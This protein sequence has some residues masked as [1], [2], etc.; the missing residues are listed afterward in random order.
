[1]S[2]ARVKTERVEGATD[3]DLE[4]KQQLFSQISQ[5]AHPI[6]GKEATKGNALPF[7]I[8]SDTPV[9]ELD[10]RFFFKVGSNELEVKEEFKEKKL[11]DL[12]D[13]VSALCE[14]YGLEFPRESAQFVEGLRDLILNEI[15]PRSIAVQVAID[16]SSTALEEVVGELQDNDWINWAVKYN[17]EAIRLRLVRFF[18]AYY[19]LTAEETKRFAEQ[20]IIPQ[21][22][23][24]SIPTK[25][26]GK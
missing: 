17:K 23:H 11:E 25:E 5:F 22:A 12:N 2:K 20:P 15:A 21:I 18:K 8:T 4:A 9:T 3:Q 13:E 1:M 7:C 10:P 6:D 14:K 26:G 16:Q 19:D 24:L